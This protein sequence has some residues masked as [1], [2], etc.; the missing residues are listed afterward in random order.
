MS[1]RK[2]DVCDSKEFIPQRPQTIREA[3]NFMLW[4][5]L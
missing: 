2:R 4:A 3:V 5:S 1:V